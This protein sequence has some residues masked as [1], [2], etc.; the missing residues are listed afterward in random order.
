MLVP[1]LW[2]NEAGALAGRLCN[3]AVTVAD[4]PMRVATGELLGLGVDSSDKPVDA[5]GVEISLAY[6]QAFHDLRYSVPAWHPDY[7]GIYWSDGLLLEVK[8]ATTALLSTCACSIKSLAG[9]GCGLFRRL[10]TGDSITPKPALS[11]IKPIL[12]RRCVRCRARYRLG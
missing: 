12:R 6:L 11:A 4:S 8:G 10:P 5:D 1:S 9:S 2:M 7:E 3:A